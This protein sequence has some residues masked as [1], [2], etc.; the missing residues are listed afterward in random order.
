MEHTYVAASRLLFPETARQINTAVLSVII[1]RIGK[2]TKAKHPS[3]VFE[4]NIRKKQV[5]KWFGVIEGG[6]K[7]S[8]KVVGAHFSARPTAVL[9]PSCH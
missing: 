2:L 4:Y 9:F 3:V 7:P 1:K 6:H 5:E 8:V